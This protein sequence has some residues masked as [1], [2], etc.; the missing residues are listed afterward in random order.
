MSKFRGVKTNNSFFYAKCELRKNA[1]KKHKNAKVIEFFCGSG[2]MYNAVYRNVE[3]YKGIDIEK[4][5]DD[6]DTV[7]SDCLSFVKNNDVSSF[8][9]FDIDAY[10]SPY[11][12]LSEIVN[13]KPVND[14]LTFIITDGIAMDLRM[15][16]VCKGA[17]ELS[18]INK[19]VLKK[20]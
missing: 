12:V 20:S 11:E 6:R 1:L 13:Q 18:G 15:G 10:G 7:K 17:R 8:N 16:R 2:V 19:H 9:V 14:I 5:N 4:F 3:T